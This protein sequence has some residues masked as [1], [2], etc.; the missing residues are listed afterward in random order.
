MLYSEDKSTYQ[1][2][3]NNKL[4]L[5]ADM[6]AVRERIEEL[7]EEKLGFFVSLQENTDEGYY[8]IY[9]HTDNEEDM[10]EE[11]L[12]LLQEKYGIDCH[13]DDVSDR[14]IKEILSIEI[15]KK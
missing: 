1:L 15:I 13:S 10:D 11:D 6:Y 5:E 14:I 12:N 9:L 4:I 8:Q 7:L 3:Q 2:Y